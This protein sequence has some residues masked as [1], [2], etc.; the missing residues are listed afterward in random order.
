MDGLWLYSS[1]SVHC[2][3]GAWREVS[4][5]VVM[6]LQTVYAKSTYAKQVLRRQAAGV[7]PVMR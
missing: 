6:W 5:K 2:W 3:T 4:S 7:A 1:H